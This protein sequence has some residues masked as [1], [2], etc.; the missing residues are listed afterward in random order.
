MV[1]NMTYQYFLMLT[2]L[3]AEVYKE[4]EQNMGRRR[5]TFAFWRLRSFEGHLR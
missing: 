5:R 4:E 3:Q 1:S 2:R